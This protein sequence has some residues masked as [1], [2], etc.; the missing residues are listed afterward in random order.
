[1]W[2]SKHRRPGRGRAPGFA[3]FDQRQ[4]LGDETLELDRADLRAVLLSVGVAGDIEVGAGSEGG[5]SMAAEVV[6]R[7]CAAAIGKV[8]NAAQRQHG[9]DAF[10]GNEHIVRYAETDCVAEQVTH[11]SPRRVNRALPSRTGSKPSG[12]SQ[13][14]CTPVIRPPR[15]VTQAIIAGQVSVGRC[16]PGR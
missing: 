7:K 14:R 9:L 16:S 3:A 12:S 6:G 2:A 8:G 5:K 1:M 10:S 15:S 11:C 4:A 13:V